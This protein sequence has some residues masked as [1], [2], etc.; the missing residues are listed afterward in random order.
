MKSGYFD[1]P[2]KGKKKLVAA[3]CTR[4]HAVQDGFNWRSIGHVECFLRY[5]EGG[6]AKID[7]S[8]WDVLTRRAR[9]AAVLVNMESRVCFAYEFR[10]VW[11]KVWWLS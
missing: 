1:R 2:P 8:V 3:V 5:A 4:I 9:D 7:I 11:R 10:F 6:G